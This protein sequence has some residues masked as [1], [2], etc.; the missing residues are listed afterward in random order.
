MTYTL[1]PGDTVPN[2]NPLV[3]TDR[4]S[5]NLDSLP[6][7]QFDVVFFTCNH[8]PYVTGSDELT[9][10]L[11]DSFKEQ[12]NFVAINS[13]SKNTYSEDSFEN[14]VLR[15]EANKF[16]WLYLHDETQETAKLFGALKTPHFFLMNSERKLLYTG[17]ATD[18]PLDIEKRKTND[19]E[20][21]LEEALAGKEISNPVTNPI[22]CNIKWDGKPA[23]WMPAEACDLI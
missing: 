20:K 19:L 23:H 9:R 16:P 3:S 15:M 14:M 11:V 8:C 22:G 21:T 1:M 10:E 13:N 2:F 7:S 5:Y 12:V 4:S 18:N 17:R 6:S